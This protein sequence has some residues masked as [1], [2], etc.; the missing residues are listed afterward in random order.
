MASFFKNLLAMAQQLLPVAVLFG[1]KSTPEL[2]AAQAA[3]PVAIALMDAAET[4]MGD[5]MGAQKKEAVTAGLK[6]FAE[7][8]A[9]LSTGG[10]KETWTI[11]NGVDMGGLIDS[12]AA[13]ANCAQGKK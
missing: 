13:T 8:M 7:K 2:A 11:I 6:A 1:L 5:G 12:I 9:E 3:A 10:Q 4:A